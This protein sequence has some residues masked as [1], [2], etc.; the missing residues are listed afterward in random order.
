MREEAP[1]LP[2]GIKPTMTYNFFLLYLIFIVQNIAHALNF[3]NLY[4]IKTF[5]FITSIL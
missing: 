2:L 5:D 1:V 3:A 4:E